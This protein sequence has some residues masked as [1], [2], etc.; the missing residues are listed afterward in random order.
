MGIVI[1]MRHK[2]YTDYNYFAFQFLS[3][4][5]MSFLSELYVVNIQMVF[6]LKRVIGQSNSVKLILQ[7]ACI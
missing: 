2:L 5:S 6:N 3:K 4:D 7:K 1:A